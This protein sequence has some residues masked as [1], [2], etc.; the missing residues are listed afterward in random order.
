MTECNTTNKEKVMISNI[1]LHTK[2]S[3]HDLRL[4]HKLIYH[5]LHWFIKITWKITQ[6]L[7]ACWKLSS[8][9]HEQFC[10]SLFLMAR[11]RFWKL[12]DNKCCWCCTANNIV[13][14]SILKTLFSK[15]NAWLL[16]CP[17]NATTISEAM[18][19]L[20]SMKIS[21]KNIASVEM[22]PHYLVW[23]R[24]RPELI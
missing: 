4:N 14:C 12:H 7:I 18:L 13:N 11:K 3:W 1:C 10:I 5:M 9:H 22:N 20:L 21:C 15:Y 8:D 24:G 2:T 16:F 23:P 17:D 19:S 6:P